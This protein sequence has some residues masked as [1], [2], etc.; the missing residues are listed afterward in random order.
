MNCN[1]L[2]NYFSILTRDEYYRGK[3]KRVGLDFFRKSFE[4]DKFLKNMLLKS[5]KYYDFIYKI[6]LFI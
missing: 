2:T 3:T 1:H 4:K 6:I 5:K